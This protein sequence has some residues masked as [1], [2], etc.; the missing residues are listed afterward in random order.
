MIAINKFTRTEI[1][2]LPWTK[3]VEKAGN[4]IVMF[5]PEMFIDQFTRDLDVETKTDWVTALLKLNPLIGF[6]IDG[7][8]AITTRA[9]TIEEI[10]EASP[11]CI[12]I[13]NSW[14]A[15]H[16]G[17]DKVVVTLDMTTNEEIID[18]EIEGLANTIQSF[19]HAVTADIVDIASINVK[20]DIFTSTDLTNLWVVDG[21]LIEIPSPIEAT[22]PL[23]LNLVPD[24]FVEGRE[25]KTDIIYTGRIIFTDDSLM[26][27]WEQITVVPDSLEI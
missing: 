5:T 19:F 7:Y 13:A 27:D 4:S 21:T 17:N 10:E 12:W 26:V 1:T 2:A 20:H 16:T 6:T 8:V 18:Q 14:F 25:P 24:D 22:G 23:I 11:N 3:L 9:V 15:I